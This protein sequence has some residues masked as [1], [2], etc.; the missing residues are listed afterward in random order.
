MTFIKL[1]RSIIPA[2]D[3]SSLKLLDKLVKET[4]KVKGIGAYKIGL[5]LVI[6]FGIKEVIKTIRKRTD[7]PI[8]YDHQK[9]ATDIPEMGEKFM[10]AV[11][12]VDSVIL[13]PMAGPVTEEKWIKA[14]F[15]EKLHVIVGGDMTHKGYL[16][17]A[18]GFIH[19][20]APKQ[21]FK[22]AANLGIRDF[23]VPGNR[24]FIINEYRRFLDSFGIK[25]IFYS[26]GLIAQG[27][28]LSEGAKA[29]GENGQAIVGRALYR[30]K[31]I[32]KAAQQM[33]KALE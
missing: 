9:A 20:M 21:M 6:P 19:N 27:G 14:A 1:K 7:L 15:K 33:V 24:P 12:G 23:V 26:P 25:P 28:S 32:K 3:V 31:N 30:A 16:E 8:I 18:G 5:E 22:I 4:C 17:R 10:K 2:C 13:F 11:K 29:A